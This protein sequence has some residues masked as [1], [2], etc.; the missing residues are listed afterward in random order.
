MATGGGVEIGMATG[1]GVE[2]GAG[3]ETYASPGNRHPAS[4]NRTP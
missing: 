3:M 1:G 2:S 4:P